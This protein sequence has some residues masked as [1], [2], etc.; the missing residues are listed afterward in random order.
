MAA[1]ERQ[2]FPAKTVAAAH[3][4][5]EIR[6]VLAFPSMKVDAKRWCGTLVDE[7]RHDAQIADGLR[8]L[9]ETLNVAGEESAAAD[10]RQLVERLV[11]LADA[12]AGNVP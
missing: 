2:P 4:A 1:A 5:R 7:L 9:L 11:A 6:R 3:Y 10:A 12:F 8:V